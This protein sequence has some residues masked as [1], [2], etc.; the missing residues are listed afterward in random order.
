[1]KDLLD[2]R[3]SISPSSSRFGRH[4]NVLYVLEFLVKGY[5]RLFI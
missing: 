2:Y 1:M 3:Q 5:L 4:P